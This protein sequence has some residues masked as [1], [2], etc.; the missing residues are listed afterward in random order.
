[1]R[2]GRACEAFPPLAAGASLLVEGAAEAAFIGSVLAASPAM[3]VICTS[4]P[5]MRLDEMHWV[6][7]HTFESLCTD[8]HRAAPT[9]AALMRD[10]LL[11]MFVEEGPTH[12]GRLQGALYKEDQR[13]APSIKCAKPCMQALQNLA[14]SVW[15][16]P[17]LCWKQLQPPTGTGKLPAYVRADRKC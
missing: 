2:P 15:L 17:H 10:S 13:R 14:S 16:F 11:W 3:W 6:G 4:Q 1:M 12:I 5:S 7:G 9:K 8:R